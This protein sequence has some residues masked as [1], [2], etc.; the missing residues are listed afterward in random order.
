MCPGDAN[1]LQEMPNKTVARECRPYD[2]EC[3]A[4]LRTNYGEDLGENAEVSEL[5]FAGFDSLLSRNVNN[6]TR[7]DDI[8]IVTATLSLLDFFSRGVGTETEATGRS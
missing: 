6:H 5:W 3:I 8:A 1:F 2:L 7:A 4:L